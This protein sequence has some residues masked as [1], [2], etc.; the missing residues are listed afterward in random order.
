MVGMKSRILAGAIALLVF[1][2]WRADADPEITI[3]LRYLRAEG[4]SHAQLY[5]FREDGKLLRQ[6]THFQSGQV[7]NPVFSPDGS[8]IVF[9]WARKEIPYAA[10]QGRDTE[11][12]DFKQVTG[13]GVEYWS[14]QPKGGNLH[15]LE[16]AP[17]WYVSA[18]DS[19]YFDNAEPIPAGAK[20]VLGWKIDASEG[21][22][23]TPDGR[24]EL[25]LR[26]LPDD[27]DADVDLPGHGKNFLLRDLKTK[28]SVELGKVK[29]F[30]GLFDLLYVGENTNDVFWIEPPLR[31]A[32]F[33][34]HLDSS[35]GDTVFALD[36]NDPQLINL[37]LNWAMPVPL[38][39][40]AAFLTLALPRY[41][42]IPGSKKTA[43][44]SCIERWDAKFHKIRYGRDT[45]TVCYG[46]SMFRTKMN[47]QVITITGP[48][49]DW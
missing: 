2:T 12:V 42:P 10:Y 17:G 45:A 1:T 44:C 40:E 9:K 32:F 18:K 3:A 7:L 14:V 25:E 30:V 29:G 49:S 41:V 6:L 11:N 19:P 27:P 36:L 48:N 24:Q 4:T 15:K 38:P 35:E 21:K 39:G 16:T 37:G 31:L 33:A 46:A 22:F 20:G 43:N 47:P 28:Q 13:E 26:S 34:V 5:L 8:V 23:T